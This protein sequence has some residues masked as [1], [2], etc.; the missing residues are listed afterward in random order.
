MIQKDIEKPDKSLFDLDYVGVKASQ[1]SFTRL[2]G[3]DP[4]L[5]VEM[6]STGEVGCLGDYFDEALLK[7]MFSVGYT[8]PKKN[9]LLSTGTIESKTSLLQNVKMLRD[10]GYKLFATRGTAQFLQRNGVETQIVTWPNEKAKPDTPNVMDLIKAKG[11]DLIINIPKNYQKEELTNDYLIR[12]AAAD[13]DI[14]LITNTR[15]AM[16][17]L[18]AICKLK[19]ED[20]G[21]KAWDEY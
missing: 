17:F 8:F 18:S 6:A 20:L 7:S 19:E 15:L 3:A 1:F 10:K 14:P 9:I 12:R 11:F 21:I 5:G 4:V 13:Y 16:A 2:Y